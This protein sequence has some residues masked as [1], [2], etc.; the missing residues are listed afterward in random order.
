[1]SSDEEISSLCLDLDLGL[2]RGQ[3][4]RE[5]ETAPPTSS[6]LEQHKNR[7]MEGASVCEHVLS[8]VRRNLTDLNLQFLRSILLL[9]VGG[10]PW[11]QPVAAAAA[12][13]SPA[14]STSNA[15]GAAGCG[16]R[17]RGLH[18]SRRTRLRCSRSSSPPRVATTCVR[19]GQVSTARGDARRVRSSAGRC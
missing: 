9:R 4:E 17:P 8:I 19:G 6:S 12:L 10:R 18:A 16:T 1:L 13:L 11:R 14:D 2:G 15:R 5:R 7:S 3:E